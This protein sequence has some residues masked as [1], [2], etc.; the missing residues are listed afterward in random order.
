MSSPISFNW[1]SKGPQA[2]H[3]R[4]YY[5]Y[6]LDQW[7]WHPS[8][9]RVVDEGAPSLHG[10]NAS[11]SQNGERLT[12]RFGWHF[13]RDILAHEMIHVRQGQTGIWNSFLFVGETEVARI[14]AMAESHN[15]SITEAE[16]GFVGRYMG[17][18]IGA[19]H[20]LRTA[21]E[22]TE[23]MKRWLDGLGIAD[24]PR[25]SWNRWQDTLSTNPAITITDT[26][27]VVTRTDKTS[28]S[29][30]LPGI[31]LDFYGTS[32]HRTVGQNNPRIVVVHST[33]GGND[34]GGDYQRTINWFMEKRDYRRASTHFIIGHDGRIA[35]V[36]PLSDAAWHTGDGLRPD[37]LNRNSIG[38][39]VAQELPST[40]YTDAQYRS[41]NLLGDA[42]EKKFGIPKTFTVV[43][44]TGTGWVGHDDLSKAGIGS[45]GKSDPGNQFSWSW[46][47][48]VDMGSGTVP[49]VEE[50]TPDLAR[51]PVQDQVDYLRVQLNKETKYRE[52]LEKNVEAFVKHFNEHKHFR[53]PGLS[54]AVG[55]VPVR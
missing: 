52:E 6:L 13:R 22:A 16:P 34:D 11:V 33:R 45:V 18:V 44:K 12:V 3:W 47:L 46:A 31:E 7:P 49:D 23:A 32:P 20:M 2:E 39:E 4:S 24:T 29:P 14:Q 42:I 30:E 28:Q 35:Q 55:F 17:S 48:G 36:V 50:P 1:L 27:A 38:I 53:Q 10:F 54:P 41:L 5:Q 26:Y 21:P 40:E 51:T 25:L 19:A 37:S 9:V 8:T 43:P 15:G